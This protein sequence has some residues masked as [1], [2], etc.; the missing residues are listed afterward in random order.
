MRVFLPTGAGWWHGSRAFGACC[1]CG[2]TPQRQRLG[3]QQMENSGETNRQYRNC[4]LYISSAVNPFGWGPEGHEIVAALAQTHLN[5]GAQL[6]IQS[7]IG[8]RS[9]ASIA[10]W[11]DEIRPE[12]DETYNW[13]FVDIPKDAVAFSDERDCFL[14]T[15]RRKDAAT[16]HHNCVVDRIEIFEHVLA[17]RNSQREARVEA[18]NFLV[19]FVGDV[20]QPFHAIGE[21]AGGNQIGVTEF[22]SAECGRFSCNLHRVWDSGLIMQSGMASLSTWPT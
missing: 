4:C 3:R 22:G 17:D 1:S 10:N 14:P 8:D 12:R 9:L 7:L 2:L 15:S 11:A 6:G 5:D 16:D 13:Q 18:L 20:H 21:A 19:H